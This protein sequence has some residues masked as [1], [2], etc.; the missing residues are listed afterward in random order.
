M[1]ADLGGGWTPYCG[2]EAAAIASSRDGGA[3]LSDSSTAARRVL[4]APASRIDRIAAGRAARERLPRTELAAWDPATRR[5]DA[6]SIVLGQNASRLASVSQPRATGITGKRLIQAASDIFVGWTNVR[7]LN[8]Y[9]RQFRDMKVTPDGQLIAPYLVQFAG[10]CGAVLARAHARTG[11]P[12]AID[13]YIG[14]GR[15]FDKAMMEFA[16]RY[17][18]QTELDH[19]Q[20]TAGVSHIASP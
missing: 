13:S 10:Q 18:D 3:A 8:F 7:R 20:L 2:G 11:D 9:V 17:A 5:D 4:A 6:V 12:I 16:R 15:R 1:R 14:K 19:A